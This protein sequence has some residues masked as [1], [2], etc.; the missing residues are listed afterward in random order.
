MVVVL[1]AR[2]VWCLEALWPA[3]VCI[4]FK[5]YSSVEHSLTYPKK[6]TQS[7]GTAVIILDT[8]GVI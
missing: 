3:D 7:V 1:N 5:Q 2:N 6:L 4:D 8:G